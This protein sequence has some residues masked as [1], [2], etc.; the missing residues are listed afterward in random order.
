MWGVS[1]VGCGVWGVSHDHSSLLTTRHYALRTTRRYSRGGKLIASESVRRAACTLSIVSKRSQWRPPAVVIVSSYTWTMH[2]LC[3]DYTWTTHEIYM[4]YTWTIHGLYMGY[5]WVTHGLY[6]DYTWTIH[7][8]CMDYTWTIHGL[9]SR[10]VAVTCHHVQLHA[11]T[12]RHFGC[13]SRRRHAAHGL[14][15]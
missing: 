10:C 2:G 3:M 12:Y 8:L 4:D 15:I 6:M 13:K 7:G 5:T 11:V 9:V 1:G 14:P